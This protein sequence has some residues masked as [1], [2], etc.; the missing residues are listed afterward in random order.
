MIGGIRVSDCAMTSIDFLRATVADYLHRHGYG[1]RKTIADAS[2][3][4]EQTIWRFVTPKKDGT[5]YKPSGPILDKIES[6][7]K[8][9]GALPKEFVNMNVYKA[10][11]TYHV[12][13]NNRPA[14]KPEVD[15]SRLAKVLAEYP[16]AMKSKEYERARRLAALAEKLKQLEGVDSEYNALMEI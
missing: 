12:P 14:H 15:N 7:M 10:P 11:A 3:I 1:A 13:Q 6:A 2:G 5:N 8:Q 4:S 9:L 16:K